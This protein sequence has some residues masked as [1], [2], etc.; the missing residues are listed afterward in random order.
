[1]PYTDMNPPNKGA[2]EAHCGSRKGRVHLDQADRRKILASI[3]ASNEAACPI[4]GT[5]E[6]EWGIAKIAVAT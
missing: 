5:F 4:C 1:M 3:P 6:C 2:A